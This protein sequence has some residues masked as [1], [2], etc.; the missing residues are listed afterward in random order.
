MEQSIKIFI[1]LGTQKFQFNRLVEAVN[2]LVKAGLYKPEDIIIQSAIYETIPQFKYYSTMP[3]EQFNNC[4]QKSELVITHSG[5]NSIVSCMKLKKPLIIAPRQKKYGEHVDNHQM[6][7][8]ALMKEKYNVIVAEEFD[9]LY[10]IINYALYHK[11][12]EW[13]S[14]NAGLIDMLRKCLN[15][16]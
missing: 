3:L 5:V 12:K 9:N 6:E 1:P 2:R 15:T 16:L 13:D 7:I 14:T 4:L 10:K 8:A 11:Y